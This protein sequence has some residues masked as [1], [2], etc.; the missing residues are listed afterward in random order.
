MRGKMTKKMFIL[1]LVVLIQVFTIKEIAYSQEAES[2]IN[3]ANLLEQIKCLTDRAVKIKD[4]AVCDRSKHVGVKYQCYAM[5]AEKVENWEICN[6][7]PTDT[8][9]LLDLKAICISD[10]AIKLM[11][12]ELCEKVDVQGFKDGCYMKIVESTGNKMLCEKISD[13]GMRSYC[14]GEPIYIK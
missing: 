4:V 6:R 13:P 14:T 7:I 1:F 10:V 11:N 9:D 3:K 8:K 2:C 12:K 5:Y